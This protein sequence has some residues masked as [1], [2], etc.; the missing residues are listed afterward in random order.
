MATQRLRGTLERA[1]RAA[2]WI[3]PAGIMEPRHR[4]Q[5]ERADAEAKLRLAEER[6]ALV[7]ELG[8]HSTRRQTPP[9]DHEAAVAFL[10]EEEGIDEQMVRDGSVPP[11]SLAFIASHLGRYL[12]A[13]PALALHVGNFVGIS[14][15][16][17]SAALRD[18]H[19]DSI[20]I[21]VDPGIPHRGVEAPDRVALRLLDR[22]GL[23]F[24][25]IVISGFSREKSVRDDGLVCGPHPA[26][27]APLETVEAALATDAACEGVLANLVRMLEGRFDLVMLDGNHDGDYLREELIDARRLLRDGGLLVLDD[28]DGGVWADIAAV[29]AELSGGGSGYRQSGF[30]GRVGLLERM[31]S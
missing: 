25:N 9:F 23:T 10:V 26:Y 18:H 16:A 5:A 6:R 4:R 17:L 27:T 19:P 24:N 30:D 28:V 7:G 8:A 20:V 3:A 29:F 31:P 14:L 2:A 21:S 11:E 1:R 15:A 13:G 12:P 22:F